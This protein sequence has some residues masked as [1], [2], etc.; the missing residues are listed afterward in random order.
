MD[1]QASESRWLVKIGAMACMEDHLRE[2]ALNI[3]A[4][5]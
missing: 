4:R 1:A 3:T 5:F 2:A